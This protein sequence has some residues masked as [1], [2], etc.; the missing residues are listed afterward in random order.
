MQDASM[1]PLMREKASLAYTAR[2]KSYAGMLFFAVLVALL[3]GSWEGADMR[4]MSLIEDSQNMATF[5][6]HFFPPNFNDW[7][8]YFDEM[9]VT[10]KIAVWGTALAVVLA[11]PCG[12]QTLCFRHEGNGPGRP[13]DPLWGG[14]DYPGRRDGEYEPDPLCGARCQMGRP[15]GQR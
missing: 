2:P 6:D 5:L 1:N 9:I 15:H 3:V 13:G 11:I 12:Q 10:I 4:P 7:Q 14:G 8:V